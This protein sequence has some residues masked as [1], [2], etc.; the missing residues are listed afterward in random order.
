MKA[1]KE[2]SIEVN[3]IFTDGSGCRP[4]GK[5]SGLCLD[6]ARYRPKKRSFAKMV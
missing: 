6:P 3:R 5:G 2:R 4:D 1:K